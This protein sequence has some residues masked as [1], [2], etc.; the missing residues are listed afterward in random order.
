MDHNSA[1]QTESTL[2]KVFDFSTS[3]NIGSSQSVLSFLFFLEKITQKVSHTIGGIFSIQS[4]YRYY[5][6]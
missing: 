1:A 6:S 3:S 5:K 2:I 4:I